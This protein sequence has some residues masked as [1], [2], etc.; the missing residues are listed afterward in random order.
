MP[1]T[2]EE[3][4]QQAEELDKE[5]TLAAEVYES[6]MVAADS[7]EVASLNQFGAST[8]LAM[9]DSRKYANK[10]KARWEELY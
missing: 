8:V 4:K 1:L 2:K 5:L 10:V 3:K 9:I 7:D 6:L